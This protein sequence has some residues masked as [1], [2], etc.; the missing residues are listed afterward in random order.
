MSWNG[1]N[2][3]ADTPRKTPEPHNLAYKRYVLI[4]VFAIAVLMVGLF[5]TTKTGKSEQTDSDKPQHRATIAHIERESSRLIASRPSKQMSSNQEAT[6]MAQSNTAHANEVAER[7]IRRVITNNVSRVKDPIEVF[8]HR[9]E[10]ELAFL[11]CTPLGTSVIGSVDYNDEFIADLKASLK[12]DII[13]SSSDDEE[14][15]F[16]KESVI[17][18]KK[19]V[20]ELMKQGEDI[21]KI[22]A[23]TRNELQELGVYKTEV[24]IMV[25]QIHNEEDLQDKEIDDLVRAANEMLSNKGIE[26]LH[27]N[28]LTRTIMRQKPISYDE[29][30]S[31][32]EPNTPSEVE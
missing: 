30:D 1:S 22:L 6:E 23:E 24:E 10:V 27:F 19:E 15:V 26:P 7:R 32:D 14:T 3:G 28:P 9:A 16:Y 17:Q 29:G 2:L 5:I 31:I 21:S 25:N 4:G 8:N 20:K 11:A 13:I 18:L 12:D